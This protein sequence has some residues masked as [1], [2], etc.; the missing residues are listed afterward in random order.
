MDSKMGF[1]PS[2]YDE[3]S[4]PPSYN[5]ALSAPDVYNPTSSTSQYYSQQ[6]QSQLSSLTSQISSLKTQ[7]SLL[8]HAQDE[9][10]LSLLTTQIQLYLSAFAKSGLR[11]GTLILVPAKGLEEENALP[12]DF[13]D[14]KKEGI[15]EYDKLVKITD[16][17]GTS[18]GEGELW[19]WND[20]NMAKRLAGYLKPAP[21][22]KNAPLPPRKEEIKA[23]ATRTTTESSSSRG[24][25]GRKKSSAS[26]ALE[27][28]PLMQ[29]R[30]EPV[31][32]PEVEQDAVKMNVEAD[33][34]VFRFENDFFVFE[35]RR[36]WAVVVKLQVVQG[37]K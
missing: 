27:T 37:K 28:P 14:K 4:A 7:K 30:K 10:I 34:I 12:T 22:L 24:F 2:S 5:D 23:T 11:R 20:E 15:I 33:E 1:P 6:I 3:E 19:F 9:K 21:D 16:K 26:K 8:A 17:D 36:G 31:E 29:D 18:I 13:E 32:M 35:T 25:W